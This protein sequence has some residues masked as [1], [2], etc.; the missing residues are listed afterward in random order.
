[1]SDISLT[2]PNAIPLKFRATNRDMTHASF[3]YNESV[4]PLHKSEPDLSH[5][6]AITKLVYQQP[7]GNVGY[8]NHSSIDMFVTGML[9]SRNLWA[10]FINCS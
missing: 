8:M 5:K 4:Q 9:H 7:K 3:Q 1:M 6:L 10:M 2:R